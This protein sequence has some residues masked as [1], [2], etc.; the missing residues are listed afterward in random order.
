MSVVFVHMRIT[1]TCANHYQTHDYSKR[2]QTVRPLLIS[3][4]SW[5]L[6]T[7]INLSSDDSRL[8]SLLPSSAFA[9]DSTVSPF[10]TS[11]RYS[12]VILR[13]SWV[14]LNSRGKLCMINQVPQRL[15]Q[16]ILEVHARMHH[17]SQ[18]ITS[19]H[20]TDILPAWNNKR[21]L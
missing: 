3:W 19:K 14:A 6:M 4:P 1:F 10:W 2:V 16:Y 5:F 12:S 15:H 17:I 8:S 21:I 20:S 11:R 9:L 18:M 13:I 7:C